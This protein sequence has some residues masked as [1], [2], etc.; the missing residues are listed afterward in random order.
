MCLGRFGVPLVLVLVASGAITGCE[1]RAR[2]P[3]Q[4]A[5]PS[6]SPPAP[7]PRVLDAAVPDAARDAA[8]DAGLA[9]DPGDVL[10]RGS[11]QKV[12]RAG[13]PGFRFC[14]EKALK[15]QPNLA[16]RVDVNIT[17]EADGTVSQA[18]AKGLTPELE[19]CMV[20]RARKLRFPP[21]SSSI[22]VHF[23][24]IFKVAP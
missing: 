16:G 13:A 2:Q 12:F 23:P 18:D 10:D 11:I 21:G 9:F 6:P 4:S 20:E 14:F 5:P 1:K 19:Q 3:R 7:L 17:I 15:Q 24:F 22:K 8:V